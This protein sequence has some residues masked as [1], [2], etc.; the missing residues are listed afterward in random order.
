MTMTMTAI[1][2]MKIQLSM[3]ISFMT[4]VSIEPPDTQLRVTTDT[5]TVVGLTPRTLT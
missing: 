1:A 4:A 2:T 5:C 3:T